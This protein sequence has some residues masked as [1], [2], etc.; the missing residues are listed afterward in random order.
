M[1]ILVF[2]LSGIGNT[3]LAL[4]FLEK[5][6]RYFRNAKIDILV[7]SKQQLDLIKNSN[8]ADKIFIFSKNFFKMLAIILRLRM[9][10]YIYSFTL[11]PSNRW[12]FN[13]LAFLVGAKKRVTHSYMYGRIKSLSFLQNIKIPAQSS[14]H[15]VE[16]NLQLLKLFNAS[17]GEENIEIKI[18][19]GDKE[20]LFAE[21]FLKKK[22]MLGKFLVGIHPGGGSSWNKRWQGERKRWPAQ[23]FVQLC[24]ELIEKKKGYVLIFGGE[25]EKELKER[26]KN[27]VIQKENVVIVEENSIIR[28]ASIIKRCS[29]FISNDTGLMHLS[30]ALGVPTLGIF[31]PTNYKR[32]APYGKFGNY[33][34]SSLKCSPCLRYP[35]YSLNSKIKCKKNFLCLQKITVKMVIDKLEELNWI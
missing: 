30:T 35:F 11:F 20:R 12:E 1:K 21:E 2:S 17:F 23:Y 27:M 32:T 5:L 25:E 22:G 34:K 28:T 14:L 15:D 13:L 8:L 6:K 24:D 33:I 31:G 3:I 7:T 26:I 19:L 9:R 18:T 4:S 10:K 16:Q 29:L